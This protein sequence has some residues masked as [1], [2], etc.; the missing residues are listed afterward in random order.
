[1][2]DD[3]RAILRDLVDGFHIPT[4]TCPHCQKEARVK[5]LV[6]FKAISVESREKTPPQVKTRS[7]NAQDSK[8]HRI[9]ADAKA[10]GMFDAFVRTVKEEKAGMVPG[11]L[12]KFFMDFLRTGR[13]CMVPARTLKLY[14]ALYDG[15]I[16]FFQSMGVVVVSADGVVKEFCPY[17]YARDDKQKV[18]M[19][20]ATF[21]PSEEKMEIW[22]R[23]RFGYVPQSSKLFE[24]AMRQPSIGEFGRMV[25]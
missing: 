16:H 11:D 14:K 24:E 18:G 13:P 10:S 15:R 5:T 3:E 25:Q 9:L 20:A 21:T 23:G 19:M 4:F 2:T 8:T 6:Q 17:S 7:E 22:V 1:M 12:D